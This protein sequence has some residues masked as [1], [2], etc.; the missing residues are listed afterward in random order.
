MDITHPDD[1]DKDLMEFNRLLKSEISSYAMENGIFG[2]QEDC[3]DRFNSF[4][5]QG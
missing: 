1:I 4:S 3:L 2:K 5:Y